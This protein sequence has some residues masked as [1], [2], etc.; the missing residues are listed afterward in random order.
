MC[1]VHVLTPALTPLDLDLVSPEP[2][3]AFTFSP[4]L[5]TNKMAASSLSD[6]AYPPFYYLF[7]T[8]EVIMST[9]LYSIGLSLLFSVTLCRLV[10]SPVHT[11]QAFR[12]CFLRKCVV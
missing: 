9:I 10:V 12:D 11:V 4:S 8:L 1:V 5:W 6:L 3:A 7:L 2:A